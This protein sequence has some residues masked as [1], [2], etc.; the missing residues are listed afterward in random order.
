MKTIRVIVTGAGSI[1][2]QG[3]LKS[4]RRCSLPVQ[5]ICTDIAAL[6]AGLFRADEA[7]I[8]PKVESPGALETWIEAITRLR[9]DVL[10]IGSEFDLEFFSR[11]R[12]RIESDT[13]CVVVASPPETVVIADDKVVTAEFLASHNLPF[14]KTG[15]PSSLQDAHAWATAMRY[16]I[17]LKPRSG[18]SARHVQIIKDDESLRYWFPRTPR[19]MLQQYLEPLSTSIGWEFT[20]SVFSTADG[21]LLGPFVSRRTLRGGSSWMVEVVDI[22]EVSELV[23]GIGKLLPSVGSL[24]VQLM[25]T[26]RGPVPFEFNARF[27]GTTP[28]RAY[29]GFNEPEMAI[30]SYFL[31]E[32]IP[33]PEIRK[34]LCIRYIE[35]IM[36]EGFSPDGLPEKFPR[37]VVNSWF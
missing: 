29:F 1:V 22:P 17:V 3:I 27:S 30:R 6:N 14:P 8:L 21:S 4:L 33:S 37:G 10:M 11:N 32:K 36:F 12:R 23:A 26:E 35:E 20:C 7:E 9:A 19:P 24:N 18:T 16:P 15:T 28:I 5:I 2:G 13:G 34:G 31:R 25:L